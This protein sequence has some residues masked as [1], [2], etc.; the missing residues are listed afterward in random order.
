MCRRSVAVL[1]VRSSEVTV[2]VGERGV[3]NTFV[4]KAS[5]TEPYDGYDES[6]FFDTDKLT[7][8]IFRAVTAVERICGERIRT[9]YV[10]VP[11]TFTRV[12]PREQN[13]GFSKR[14]VIGQ[15]DLSV[16]FESGREPV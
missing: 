4:F 7:D 16:L 14:R 2:V 3:N 13:I 12:I 6:A 10:G 1:D 15:R 5:K 8:A 9:L 11:G